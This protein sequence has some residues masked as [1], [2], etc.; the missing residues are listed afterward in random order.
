M[1]K[2][3]WPLKQ[4]DWSMTDI[5][6]RCFCRRS[7]IATLRSTAAT[8]LCAHSLAFS[9]APKASSGLPNRAV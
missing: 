5:F 2:A 3:A 1:Y 9:A 8:S 6:A 7:W 4:S